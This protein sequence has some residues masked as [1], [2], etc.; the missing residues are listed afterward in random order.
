MEIWV[1]DQQMQEIGV[2]EKYDSFIWTDRYDQYGDFELYSGFSMELWDQLRNGYYLMN[3]LSDRIMMIEDG[4]ISYDS[5][6]GTHIKVVGRSLEALLDRRIVWG[7]MIFDGALGDFAAKLIADNFTDPNTVMRKISFIKYGGCDDTAISS[8]EI[9]KDASGLNVYD[10]LTEVL[11]EKGCGFKALWNGYPITD[12]AAND[13]GEGAIVVKLYAGV[14][15]SY[16]QSTRPYVVFSPEYDN[17]FNSSFNHTV[18]DSKNVLLI[19]GYG[20]WSDDKTTVSV[21]EVSGLNRREA[22]EDVS[23][24]IEPETD[25]DGNPIISDGYKNRLKQKGNELLAD[26]KEKTIMDGEIDANSMYTIGTDYAVGDIVELIDEY[27]NQQAVRVNEI[28]YSDDEEG[29]KV[30]PTFTDI[31]KTA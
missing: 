19:G 6:T 7:E 28:I 24:Q 5:E 30:Y 20:S 29:F 10:C 11:Q 17:L 18:S 2:L 16:N 15:R 13:D 31:D 27:G 14:D 23:S 4:D 12:N 25:S 8:T 21:G 1:L 22:Y 9:E 3:S 26:Y